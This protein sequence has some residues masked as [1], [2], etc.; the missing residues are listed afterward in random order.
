MPPLDLNCSDFKTQ[1]EAQRMLNRD[2]RD[3]HRLDGDRDGLACESL[4]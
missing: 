4:P 2:R 3:P 1:A